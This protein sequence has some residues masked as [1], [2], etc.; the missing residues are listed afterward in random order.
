MHFA[1]K[2]VD[3]ATAPQ[4][5]HADGRT[6]HL[7]HLLEPRRDEGKPWQAERCHVLTV[8]SGTEHG[9]VINIQV[10]AMDNSFQRVDASLAKVFGDLK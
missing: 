4:R 1:W 5:K 8:C 2:D 9:V 10:C 3:Y 7:S 6:T